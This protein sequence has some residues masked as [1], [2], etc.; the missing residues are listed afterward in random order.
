MA[1]PTQQQV[2]H[3]LHFRQRAKERFGLKISSVQ[4]LY[5]IT[6]VTENLPGTKFIEHTPV[7]GRTMWRIRAGG[8]LMRVIF[9]HRTERL[10]TC[11]PY[12]DAP[13]RPLSK[14][15]RQQAARRKF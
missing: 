7:P 4:Y 14:R 8:V 2:A 11:L 5:L 13:T 9:D 1:G 10:V 12:S 6:K 3:E 15:E